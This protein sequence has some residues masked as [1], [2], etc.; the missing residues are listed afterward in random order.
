M[1][2]ALGRFTERGPLPL[3]VLFARMMEEDH[4]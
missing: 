4:R 2:R 3:L 1:R